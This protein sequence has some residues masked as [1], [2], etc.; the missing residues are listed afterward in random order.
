MNL[1]FTT[2]PKPAGC[3]RIGGEQLALSVYVGKRP[4]WLTRVMMRLLL[5]W[6]WRDAA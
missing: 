4:R 5:E 2:L 1:T 6:E 3:W